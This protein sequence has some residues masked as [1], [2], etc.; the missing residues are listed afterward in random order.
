MPSN[1]PHMTYTYRLYLEHWDFESMTWYLRYPF[2]AYTALS[3][4][5]TPALV[6]YDQQQQ[7]VFIQVQVEKACTKVIAEV[8]SSTEW[9]PSHQACPGVIHLLSRHHQP[10][11]QTTEKLCDAAKADDVS[12][13]QQHLAQL[14]RICPCRPAVQ[15]LCEKA[16]LPSAVAQQIA[17]LAVSKSWSHGAIHQAV[18]CA[19][20]AHN[21][22][23]LLEILR[24]HDY[25]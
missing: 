19:H 17:R 15:L 11:C 18:V 7:T 4:L 12:Q 24:P 25:I 20:A 16:G 23:L 2:L 22:E 10:W 9:K 1:S 13:V 3:L 5:D 8:P 14:Y 6:E 21:K